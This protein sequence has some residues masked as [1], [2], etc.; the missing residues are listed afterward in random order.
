[1][2]GWGLILPDKLD[3]AVSVTRHG[4]TREYSHH[5]F[6]AQGAR[7]Q[8]IEYLLLHEFYGRGFILPDKLTAKEREAEIR[9]A[10]NKGK[11][12]EEGDYEG[13]GEAP[14]GEAIC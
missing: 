5:P 14:A 12:E 10:K 7:A 8:R 6:F 11:A 9:K 2:Y 13:E 3:L 1:L 4:R